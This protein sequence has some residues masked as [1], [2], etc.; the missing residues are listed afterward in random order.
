MTP[1]PLSRPPLHLCALTLSKHKQPV[2]SPDGNIFDR[3]LIHQ[4]VSRTHLDPISGHTLH[5]HQLIPLIFS[6]NDHP[7]KTSI[8]RCP[9]LYT[10]LDSS[11][12]VIVV[13]TTGRVYS[14]E[15]IERLNLARRHMRDLV[16]GTPFSL[17]DLIVLYDP[18]IHFTL[19]SA[20][21]PTTICTTALAPPPISARRQLPTFTAVQSLPQLCHQSTLA[22]ELRLYKSQL[23]SVS[24]SRLPSA[25]HRPPPMKKPR[26]MSPP[27]L[28]DQSPHQHNPMIPSL[29]HKRRAEDERKAVYKRIRKGRKGKGYV[30]VVTNIGHLNIELHCDKVPTTCDNFLT[31]AERKYYDGLIWHRVVPGYIAQTGDP[32]GTGDNGDSAWGGFVKDEIRTSLNH[33]AP[34]VVSMA[35]SGRDTNRS[36]WFVCFQAARELDGAHTVFGKVVGGLYVLKEMENEAE[37][38]HPLTVERIEVLV[39]PIRQI[40]EQL[41]QKRGEAARATT[42]ALPAPLSTHFPLKP[43]VLPSAVPAEGPSPQSSVLTDPVPSTSASYEPAFVGRKVVT[44]RN[45]SLLVN[46]SPP[47]RDRNSFVSSSSLARIISPGLPSAKSLLSSTAAAARQPI[48]R[49]ASSNR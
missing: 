13:A 2:A 6:L 37:L 20:A 9:F 48:F 41:R 8:Y 29:Y 21:T 47:L 15:A 7:S 27:P 33:D 10:P 31:L 34:G 12:K 49:S 16:D 3:S 24:V 30:R 43:L 39:N 46:D 38:S 28:T 5:P 19:P 25:E 35:N 42:S 18:A 22:K 11:K 26:C 36:Q 14:A 44:G 1:P 45:S 32:T 4:L 23:P 40:R 17:S